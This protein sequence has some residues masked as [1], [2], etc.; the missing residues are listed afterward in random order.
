MG[1]GKGR[2]ILSLS[3][4]KLA[5]SYDCWE[6]GP[7]DCLSGKLGNRGLG[8]RVIRVIVTGYGS[9]VHGHMTSIEGH[10]PIV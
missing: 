9:R 6:M 5:L 2:S 4:T 7:L 1:L 8:L 10:S 3:P